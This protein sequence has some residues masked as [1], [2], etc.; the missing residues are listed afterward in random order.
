MLLP[1]LLTAEGIPHGLRTIG[2][3]PAVYVFAGIGFTELLSRWRGVFPKNPAA[4]ST[5]LVILLGLLLLSC[6]YDYTRYFKAWANN[7]KTYE[8]YS[9]DAVSVGKF[10][11]TNQ[12]DGENIAV[13]DSYSNITVSYLT[14]NKASY[15]Q[16]EASGLEQQVSP[17]TATRLVIAKSQYE[18]AKPFLEANK[19][20]LKQQYESEHRKNVILYYV[21]EIKAQQ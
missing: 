1:A 21:Y 18:A 9:E 6:L 7:P 12:F 19:A 11:I 14:H 16:L 10:L 5:G 3:I 2:V 4:R 17:N 8:A 20:E 15:R 13:I